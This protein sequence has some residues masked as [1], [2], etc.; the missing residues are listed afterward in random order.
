MITTL[1]DVDVRI[2]NVAF[3]CGSSRTIIE[4]VRPEFLHFYDAAIDAGKGYGLTHGFPLE[5]SFDFSIGPSREDLGYQRIAEEVRRISLIEGFEIFLHFAYA[6]GRLMGYLE[7]QEPERLEFFN[8]VY[9]A[10]RDLK[11]APYD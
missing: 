4:R 5:G 11:L 9:E 7:L 8:R 2:S 10:G 3:L 1:H 6:G